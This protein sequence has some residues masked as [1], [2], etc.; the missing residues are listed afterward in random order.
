L[1]FLAVFGHIDIVSVDNG[2]ATKGT[3]SA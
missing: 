2:E 1:L 3:P